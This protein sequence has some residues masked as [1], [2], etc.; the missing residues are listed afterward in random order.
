MIKHADV[1]CGLGFGDEGKGVTVARLTA[2]AAQS[3]GTEKSAVVR[4]SG[5]PQNAHNVCWRDAEG[6]ARHHKFAQLGAGGPY[7][8]SV[9]TFTAA[10]VPVNPISLFFEADVWTGEG[11]SDA[12]IAKICAR[13][14]FH[15]DSLLILPWHERVSKIREQKLR[16]GSTG[17]GIFE[18]NKFAE[19]HPDSAIRLRDLKEPSVL[20]SKT[21]EFFSWAN[22]GMPGG[23]SAAIIEKACF[24]DIDASSEVSD[25]PEFCKRRVGASYAVFLRN[26][27]SGGEWLRALGEKDRL[28]F[29]GGQGILLDKRF[30]FFP[31]VT[32]S[33]AT[34]RNAVAIIEKLGE[35]L[36]P[37]I[38]GVTRTYATR[39]GAGIL[40]YE[41]SGNDPMCEVFRAAEP[42]NVAS[43]FTGDMRFAPLSGDLLDYA[44]ELCALCGGRIT[45]VHITHCDTANFSAIRRRSASARET[46]AVVHKLSS[47]DTGRRGVI[48]DWANK[49]GSSGEASVLND[50]AVIFENCNVYRHGSPYIEEVRYV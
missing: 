28:V 29:E 36:K 4:Y 18:V 35:N 10:C 39:H 24:T 12:E 21:R 40:P 49:L 13:R 1:V 22:D 42:H 33:D 17:R 6:R 23:R 25:F 26:V 9:D 32:F 38:H 30:G 20:F 16:H 31:N 37:T 15:E 34:P 47:D 41:M 8:F 46:A 43:P 48:N 27:L 44:T 11:H 19:I 3:S 50:P 45:D 2:K 14:Y 7:L 5:G